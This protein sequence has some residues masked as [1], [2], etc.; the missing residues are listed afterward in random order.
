MKA[1]ALDRFCV[2]VFF[3]CVGGLSGIQKVVVRI[4]NVVVEMARNNM[5]NVVGHLLR[6]QTL[7]SG[8]Q[9]CRNI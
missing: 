5:E 4:L 9:F 3:C 6:S 8:N 1:V 2:C 7:A